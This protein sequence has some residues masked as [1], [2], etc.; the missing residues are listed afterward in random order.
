MG[1]RASDKSPSPEQSD[2][3][4][5]EQAI[6]WFVR[7]RAEDVSEEERQRF[8]Q[9]LDQHPDHRLAYA[10]VTKL[11]NTSELTTAT[12]KTAQNMRRQETQPA[13]PV[14]R[15][16]MRPTLFA[17]MSATLLLLVNLPAITTYFLQDYSTRA[18]Q[19][20]RISLADG[21]NIVL[22]TA[23]AIAVAYNANER[24][25]RLLKG[26]VFLD[27]SPDP[28]RP[29]IVE[30]EGISARAVGT[31]YLVHRQANGLEVSVLEGIV[32][33][34]RLKHDPIQLHPQQQ[35]RSHAKTAVEVVTDG[36]IDAA[37][38]QGRLVLNNT[39]LSAA[40]DEIARYHD[41]LLTIINPSIE[42]FK[43]SG[44][45]DLKQPLTILETLEQT[46]PIKLLRLSNRVILVY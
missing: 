20:Q 39:P 36:P 30:S 14:F 44:S 2:Q 5:T 13:R 15:R 8:K 6:A 25:I 24:R 17:L 9:W 40:L 35:F 4:L 27:V 26:E 7:L 10:N 18:G 33:V 34:D 23:S 46:L 42:N 28:Q 21:S 32:E 43:V 37:W 22:N 1:N 29:F 16:F 12:Q 38:L 3:E 45:F 41:G 19:Q 11:W 31:Q